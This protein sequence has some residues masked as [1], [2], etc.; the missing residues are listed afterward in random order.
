MTVTLTEEQI[1]SLLDCVDSASE[2]CHDAL[3]D[4]GDDAKERKDAEEAIAYWRTITEALQP[5]TIAWKKQP[6]GTQTAS[7]TLPGGVK[8]KARIEPL[9]AGGFMASIHGRC[10]TNPKPSKDK[11]SFDSLEDAK[12][13]VQDSL[14]TQP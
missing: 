2:A 7:I 9:M 14:N 10:L 11:Y 4:A 12:K 5:R 13:A 6:T 3:R 8:T 1:E